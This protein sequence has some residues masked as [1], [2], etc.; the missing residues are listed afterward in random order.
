M[1]VKLLIITLFFTA[2]AL[3]ALGINMLIKKHGRFP[4][5]HIS[6]N[7]EMRKR[8]ISCAQHTN[9]GCSPSDSNACSSCSAG[10]Q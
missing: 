8:G 10:Q 7:R 5:T 1:F 2:V 3:A 9:L 6:R 4:E